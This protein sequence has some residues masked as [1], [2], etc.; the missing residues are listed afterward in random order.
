MYVCVCGGGGG[1]G[2]VGWCPVGSGGGGGGWWGGGGGVRGYVKKIS[3]GFGK[4][5]L[6]FPEVFKKFLGKFL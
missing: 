6:K 4:F 3:K 2:G 5:S 1:E